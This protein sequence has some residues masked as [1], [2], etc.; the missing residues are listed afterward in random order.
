MNKHKM[1]QDQSNQE[2]NEQNSVD[3]SWEYH[4]S[5]SETGSNKSTSSDYSESYNESSDDEP[6]HR[7]PI[8]PVL[9]SSP[10]S[11]LANLPP[12]PDPPQRD[13]VISFKRSQLK[14]CNNV[15]LRKDIQMCT[16]EF[17]SVDV[18]L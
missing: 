2:S 18:C 7:E 3:H 14:V 10:S 13:H 1:E 17:C 9:D 8:H 11:F 12:L 4:S 15:F 16:T 5:S 6:V